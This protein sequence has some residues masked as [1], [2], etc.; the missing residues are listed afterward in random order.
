M[1]P[2]VR[3]LDADDWQLWK[4][5]RLRALHDAPDAF[6]STLEEDG[7]LTRDEWAAVVGRTVDHPRGNLW[8]AEVGEE[9]VGMMFGRLTEDFGLLEINAMWVAPEARRLGAGRLLL[10]AAFGWARDAGAKE[11]DLW[12]T[13]QNQAA[14]AFYEAAG[15]KPTAETKPLREG[16]PLTIRKLVR[17][18]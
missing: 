15:F 17:E 9:P 13:E 12:V 1:E 5:L 2:T 8:F 10:D 7:A 11:A 16:S 18:L 3:T 6:G 4:A 14:V